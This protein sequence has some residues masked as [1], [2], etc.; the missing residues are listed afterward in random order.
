M[1]I[2]CVI[3]M[4]AFESF[5]MHE[6]STASLVN[7][8]NAFRSGG[9]YAPPTLPYSSFTPLHRPLEIYVLRHL[10]LVNLAPSL[11]NLLNTALLHTQSWNIINAL[12]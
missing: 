9:T 5:C 3:S 4:Y 2:Y 12:V 10:H 11:K 8:Y 6:S 7:A 1:C